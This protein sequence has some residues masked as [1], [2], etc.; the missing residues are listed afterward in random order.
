[1]TLDLGRPDDAIGRLISLA[2]DEDVGPGDLTAEAVVPADARGSGLIFAK[3]SLTVSGV[4]AAARVFRALDP[5]CALE[6]LKDEGDAAGP[7]DGV[8][9]VRGSLRAILTGERTALNLMMRLCGIA[10]LTRRYVQAL[11]GTKTRLLDT[12]KTTPGMRELEKAAV[13]AGGGTKSSSR[14]TTRRPR[15]ES[16]RPSGARGRARTR[17]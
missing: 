10:T 7:G 8:L 14:T 12:R 16:A 6:P 9:R 1:M 5:A 11:Q 15:A 17:C 3:E 2:L 4:S 13:R